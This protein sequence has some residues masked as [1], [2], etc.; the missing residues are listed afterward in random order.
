MGIDKIRD[1]KK[2]LIADWENAFAKL[3]DDEIEQLMPV[4]TDSLESV[5][6]FMTKNITTLS[7]SARNFLLTSLR[8]KKLKMDELIVEFV[9]SARSRKH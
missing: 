9:Q 8:M 2:D 3:S 1:S 5:E 7:E 4:T 6:A